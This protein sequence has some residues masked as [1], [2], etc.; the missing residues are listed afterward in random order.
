M[1]HDKSILG[2]LS[3][4]GYR[5]GSFFSSALAVRKVDGTPGQGFYELMKDL[6]LISNAKSEKA[7]LLW[8]DDLRKAYEWYQ[9]H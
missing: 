5:S 8:T 6:R 7:M 2:F 3:Y 1:A 9:A 4:K